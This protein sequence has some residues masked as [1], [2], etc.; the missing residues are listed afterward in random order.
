MSGGIPVLKS[1]KGESSILSFVASFVSSVK[2][3]RNNGFNLN[4]D[5]ILRVIRVTVGALILLTITTAILIPQVLPVSGNSFI[6]AK[7]EWIRTPIDGDLSFSDLK[8]GDYIP[9][10]RVLGTITNEQIDDYFLNQL[11]MEKSAIESALFSLD[12]RKGFCLLYT[13]PSPRD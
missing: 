11:K 10:G 4:T 12:S 13:S 9:E 5:M 8:I 2:G 1:T 7:L 6:N 3:D